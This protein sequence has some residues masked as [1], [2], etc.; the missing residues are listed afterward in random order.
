MELENTCDLQMNEIVDIVV[1]SFSILILKTLE[2]CKRK[3]L[4]II[5]NETL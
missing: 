1:N 2:E 3:Q 4:L 5:I